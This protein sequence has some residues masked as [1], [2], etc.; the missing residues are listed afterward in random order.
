[1]VQTLSPDA[2]FKNADWPKKT[3]DTAEDLGIDLTVEPRDRD[4]DE[5]ADAESG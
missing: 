1:M 3:P 2:D 5:D 4:E